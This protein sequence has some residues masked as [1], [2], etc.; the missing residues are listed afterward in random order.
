MR[1]AIIGGTGQMGQWFARLFKKKGNSVVISGRSYAK[2]SRIARSIGVN[3]ARTGRD[4]VKGAD[5]VMLSVPPSRFESV[6]KGISP[7]IS[8]DQRVIDITS[9]K[10][11]PVAIMH[12][13]LKRQV[14]LGTHPMFGPTAEAKG[15]NFI[16]TPTNAKERRFANELAKTLRGYG[17]AVHM[18][19]PE[20]HDETIGYILSLTH[21]IGFV[22]ADTW[23]ELK[24]ERYVD[25]SSTSFQFLL[26]FAKSVVDSDPELYSH[27]Q[28]DVPTSSKAESTFVNQANIWAG[29]VRKKERRRFEARMAELSRYLSRL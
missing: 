9:I 29:M 3:A 7:A 21:F 10:S 11:L 6:L 5:L 15:Q 13:Y 14:V 24:M 23:K 2:S 17:F 1:I 20:K 28:M 4:A 12:K 25:T 27:I 16:L 19:T 18:T 26:K 22:T 8:R